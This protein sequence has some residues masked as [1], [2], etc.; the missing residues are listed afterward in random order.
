MYT[1]LLQWNTDPTRTQHRWWQIQVC[2]LF[3]SYAMP[4]TYK[5]T[6]ALLSGQFYSKVVANPIAEL[7]AATKFT[8]I[9]AA[10]LFDKVMLHEVC[11]TAEQ[12]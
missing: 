7:V 1:R 2:P 8:P 10:S 9:D 6:T 4:A 12:T 3:L 11:R 5:F